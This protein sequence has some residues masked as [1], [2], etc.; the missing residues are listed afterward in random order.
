M[1]SWV[2]MAVAA[3]LVAETSTA[4]IC[5]TGR[6]DLGFLA[7]V[8]RLLGP[9]F[10][11]AAGVVYAFL[12]YALLV[13]YSSQGGALLFGADPAVGA[14]VFSAVVGGTVAFG[15]SD[16]VDGANDA[17]VGVVVISF[18]ALVVL[19][20]PAFDPGRLLATAPD[21]KAAFE[22]VPISVLALVYHNVVPLLATRLGGDR[23]RITRAVVAGSA[24]PLI[25]FLMWN[26][27][28]LGAVDPGCTDPVA[29]L[30]A[31]DGDE[32][33]A[34]GVAVQVF[35]FAA[36]VTSFTGFYYGLRTYVRDLLLATPAPADDERFLAT[37]VLVPPTLLAMSRP[38]IFLPALDTAGTFGITILFG[39]VPAAC[40]WQLRRDDADAEAESFVPGG[41]AVLL[42]MAGLSAGII[43][44]G[45]LDRLG[46]L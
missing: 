11:Q 16:V 31:A 26:A 15:P 19:G 17:L 2:F 43:F 18:A 1:A 33:A 27:L 35:S 29:S 10:G 25:I 12:H 13:A 5:Q 8:S 39:I 7:T 36:V 37:A 3:L 44:E 9:R 41:D 24:I 42:V 45:A 21:P 34:L 30:I 4:V 40:A 23:R 22:A 20:L 14:A 28:I 38:D 32:A 6:A 46:M